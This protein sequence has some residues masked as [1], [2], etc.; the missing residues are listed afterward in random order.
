MD[1]FGG[2]RHSSLPTGFVGAGSSWYLVAKL[3]S[4]SAGRNAL[5]NPQP[6]P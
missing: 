5:P 4:V 2:F 3:Q 6:Y 1:L